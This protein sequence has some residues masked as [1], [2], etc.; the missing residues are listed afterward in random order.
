MFHGSFAFDVTE[1]QVREPSSYFFKLPTW[2][3]LDLTFG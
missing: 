2:V 3:V 1:V